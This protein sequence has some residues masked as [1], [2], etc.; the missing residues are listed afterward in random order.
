MT[1][2]R[3]TL[4]FALAALAALGCAETERCPDGHI[5]DDDGTCIPIPDGGPPRRD[6]AR[7][8]Q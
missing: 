2:L 8:G 6:A 1:L 7:D 4:A 5:F 3:L